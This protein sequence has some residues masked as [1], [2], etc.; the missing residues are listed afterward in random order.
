MLLE[1]WRRLES[2]PL[3]RGLPQVYA[4]ITV[5][6]LLVVYRPLFFLTRALCHFSW[7]RGAYLYNV[8]KILWPCLLLGNLSADSLLAYRVFA[9]LPSPQAQFGLAKPSGPLHFGPAAAS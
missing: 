3:R 8:V 9:F 6:R 7:P 2:V 5:I 1:P 4:A